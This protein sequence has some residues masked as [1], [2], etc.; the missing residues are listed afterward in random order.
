MDLLEMFLQEATAK[1]TDKLLEFMNE[2]KDDHVTTTL[3]PCV[4]SWGR[5]SE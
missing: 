1:Q 2:I 5:D 3:W 4:N